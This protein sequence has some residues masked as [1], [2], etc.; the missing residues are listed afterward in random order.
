[1]WSASPT[2][3]Q[4]STPKTSHRKSLS[5]GEGPTP[6]PEDQG[7]PSVPQKKRLPA[8]R[9][10]MRHSDFLLS[11]RNEEIRMTHFH[12]AYSLIIFYSLPKME[13]EEN[14]QLLMLPFK[15]GWKRELYLIGDSGDGDVVYIHP[16]GLR[17]K[18]LED[19]S[20]HCK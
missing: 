16:W 7:K 12:C 18:S 1:M 17:L 4:V 8:P 6:V 19:L 3:P 2:G 13:P 11:R 9:K 10:K 15:K 20:L 5:V 14:L